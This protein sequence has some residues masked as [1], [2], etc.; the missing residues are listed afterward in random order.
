MLANHF[1]RPEW[2]TFP[3][4]PRPRSRFLADSFRHLSPQLEPCLTRPA[5]ENFEFFFQV[6]P[7]NDALVKQG[8][9]RILNLR[10]PFEAAVLHALNRK[11]RE[12]DFSI[13]VTK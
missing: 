13:H 3:A 9:A 7:E 2:P 4:P 8:P 5:V 12:V 1:L 6:L 10:F 11:S